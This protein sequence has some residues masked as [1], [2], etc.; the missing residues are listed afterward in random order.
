M[1]S[2]DTVILSGGAVKGFA[3]M[4]ALQF[5]M[6]Q[7]AL[8]GVQKYIGTSIGAILGY[9]MCIGYSPVE[10]MVIFC[11]TNWLNKLAHFDICNVMQGT[12]ALSFSVI[13]D[14]LEKLTVQKIGRFITLKQLK[15]EYGKTLICCTYN[16]TRDTEEFLSPEDHPD[17]PCL[18]ALRMS[19]NLPLVFEPFRYDGCV[20]MDGGLTCNFPIHRIQPGDVVLGIVLTQPPPPDSTHPHHVPSSFELMWKV[21]SIPMARLQKARTQEYEHL[22][23]LVRVDVGQYFTL[24]FDLSN[25]EKFDM[26]SVGYES[27]KTY[28][29]P[30]PPQEAKAEAVVMDS[31]S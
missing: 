9:L 27:M 13:M 5:A 12:G 28:F 10:I 31:S 30:H 23:D 11:Q 26:F 1:K 20:Y 8:T 7:G 16:Y 21:M 3:L 19:A 29:T 24:Q 4:G 18:T 15:E 6:D 2:Y 17:I 22:C 14:M 25:S